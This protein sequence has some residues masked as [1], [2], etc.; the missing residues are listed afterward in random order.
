MNKQTLKGKASKKHL[1]KLLEG[2][3]T[4]SVTAAF[5][6]CYWVTKGINDTVTKSA[7]AASSAVGQRK[8]VLDAGHGGFDGGCV[9]VNGTL[10][11]DINLSITKSLYCLFELSGFDVTATRLDD[12]AL[13][14]E[15]ESIYDRKQSD[16]KNRF[17]LFS[18]DENAVCISVHQNQYTDEQYSGAQM[19]YSSKNPE[20]ELLAQ[21]LQNSVTEL[22]QPENQ[23]E[24]K[25]DDEM[26]MLSGSQISVMA[27]CG[28]L[29]NADE[30]KLLTD[31]VY[32]K[33]LAAAIFRGTMNFLKTL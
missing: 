25:L 16:M 5:V 24:I 17:E 28:F 8:I 13:D 30:E 21:S 29:S 4:L 19:F 33:K 32:Q 2:A 1:R 3:V 22:L 15:G 20:S 14:S 27:E 26:Y 18:E 10:E 12:E 31:A 7:A 23:R 6:V 11:K 9:G